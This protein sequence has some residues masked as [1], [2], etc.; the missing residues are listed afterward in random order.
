MSA[1]QDLAKNYVLITAV[2]SWVIAQ[3]IKTL[4]HLVTTRK[5]EPERLFGAGGM[6]S[7]HSASVCSLTLAVART[8]GLDSPQFAI[9]FILAAVVMYDAMGVRRAAGEHA[10]I[11]NVIMRQQEPED[12]L[13]YLNKKKKELKEILGH[14]PLEV[15]SGALLGIIVAMLIPVS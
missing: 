6:P 15:I 9:S 12:I 2:S 11:L 8:C 1:L 7:A 3:V 5:F 4:L 14:T 13:S 10:R